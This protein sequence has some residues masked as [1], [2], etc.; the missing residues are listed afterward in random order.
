MSNKTATNLNVTTEKTVWE[1]RIWDSIGGLGWGFMPQNEHT[2]LVG[3]GIY[4]PL[5]YLFHAGVS[6]FRQ[7]TYFMA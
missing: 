2:G 7:G 1:N 3:W 6:I 4:F 5:G